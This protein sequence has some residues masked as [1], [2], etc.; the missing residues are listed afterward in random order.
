M[1]FSENWLREWFDPEFDSNTLART[2][3][4][5]GHEVDSVS[6]VGGGLDGVVIAEILQ[7]AKHPDADRLS[8]CQVTTGGE[9]TL[10]VVCGAP[11]VRT[12]MKSPLAAPGVRL[13][14]GTKLRKSKI[15]GVISHGMLCSAVELGLGEESD[16]IIELPADAKVGE[17]LADL[18]ALPDQVIDVDLTPNRGDCFSVLGIAR[19]LAAMTGHTLEAPSVISCKPAIAD[20]QDVILADPVACPR[21][22]GRVIRNIESVARSPL[23]LKERLR[24]S[25]IRSIHP[26]VD[27]TNYVM[28]ELGQPLHAYDL[29]KIQG[30]IRPRFATSGEKVMLLDE[31]EIELSADTVAI[32]DDSGPI[33]LAGIMGGLSTAVSDLSCNIFFEAA[34]WPQ[35]VIAGR[36]RSYNMHTDAS[37]RFERGV[38]ATGQA[39]A[40][41]RATELLLEI[42]GGQ[43]GPLTDVIH[44]DHLPPDVSIKLR[45]ARLSHL[46]GVTIETGKVSKA[47]NDLGLTTEKSDDGWLVQIP[48]HRFDLNLEVDLIEEVARIYGYNE[49]PELT[50]DA[51]TPL[52][53]APETDVNLDQVADALVMR[54]FQEAI[55]YTFVDTATDE[56]FNPD[57]SE[58]VLANPISSE[59]S[60]MR[61]SLLG[62]LLDA[63]VVNLSRQQDR[64]RLF[65]IGKSFHG[66]LDSPQEIVRLSAVLSGGSTSEQWGDRPQPVDFFDIKSDVE[67]L[68]DMTGAAHEFTFERCNERYLQPGQ[69]A[70]ILRDN[71]QVGVV[72]KLHPEVAK[73]FSIKRDVF[74]FELDAHE[75]FA[76]SLARATSISKFPSIRRDISIVIRDDVAAA[77]IVAAIESGAPGVVKNVVIFDIYRGPGIEVGLKSVALGLI[78]QET[79]RTLTDED[80]D[81]AMDAAMSKLHQ[82]FAAVLRE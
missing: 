4:M 56:R 69:A 13:P 8:V 12:G 35:D 32:T 26:V 9:A 22:A 63:L 2:L 10:E 24:R 50:A 77:E 11:N 72:G 42:S 15:R 62:G 80:A 60:L 44:P 51:A 38:D 45:E 30:A 28:L 76:A 65:E 43:P 58:L 81:S 67:S 1:K 70:K 29:D 54:D 64:V 71:K 74:V 73:L 61:S 53:N 59:M 55:T 49:I 23:W 37:L 39:R 14:D 17:P 66:T 19:D 82:E 47:L 79:S 40:I 75:F 78:L 57:K 20:Q 6:P 33:G 27:V 46:L 48:G 18:L 21:F 68:I 31:R 7:V 3:T 34:F 52:A 5:A 25:G 41:E 36:A 16:G